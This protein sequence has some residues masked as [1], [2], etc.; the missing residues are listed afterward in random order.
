M[1][2]PP[3]QLWILAGGNGAGKS[4]FYRTR[5]QDKGIE[6]IN[7]DLIEREIDL[8]ENVQASYIAAGIARTRFREA[9]EQGRSFCFETVFSHDSKLEMLST[10]KAQ[11]YHVT[12]VF[13][14]LGDTR[15]NE[16]RVKQRVS[17]GGHSVPTEKIATRIPRTLS[18]MRHAMTLA[19]R[20][21]LLDNS[22]YQD[23]FRQV[24]IKQG[25]EIHIVTDALPDWAHALLS[26]R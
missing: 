18:L 11:G 5:L 4:T 21:Y 25:E 13:I 14:H 2:S 16:L 3:P 12:L 8:T 17:E 9:I 10:A 7:A 26:D 1:N 19:D 22:S 6:F 24:A 20:T 23:P 15:L